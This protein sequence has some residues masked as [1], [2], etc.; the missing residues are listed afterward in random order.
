MTLGGLAIAIGELVDDAVVDVENIFRRLGENRRAGNPRS[1]F[2]VVVSAS[3]EVRSGIVYATMVIVLVFVPLF[4]LS[5]IEGRLFAPLGQ[6]YIVSILASLLVSITLTP[7]LAYY[8]LPGLKR[9]EGHESGL[10]RL[11]KRLN[12]ALLRALLGHAR[13]VMVSAALAVAAAGLA[14][15]FLPRAFLPPSTRARSPSPWPSPRHL[16]R[17]ERPDRRRCGASALEMPD[18]KSIGRRTGRAE[19]DEHAEGVHSSDLEIDLKPGA[20]PKPDLVAEIRD[21]L[22]VLP[23]SVNVGQPISHR[24]DHMLSGVRAEIALKIF[25][26]DLDTLRSLA[27]DLR[28]RLGT[29]P[30][31]ADLQVEKQVL[32]PQLEIRVDYARAAL[33][34][35]QPAALIEQLSRLSNGQVVSAW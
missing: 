30:G 17:G 3:N 5:G 19:L 4:A 28:R 15:A 27:E 6:A 24:L 26:D 35:V 7:V 10:I 31:I 32:I 20:R 22:A 9:L 13:P 21:R 12:A 18:V 34:G 14:A 33:Y 1:V 29:I 23:V 11:L 2:A 25:G 8:L 16:A